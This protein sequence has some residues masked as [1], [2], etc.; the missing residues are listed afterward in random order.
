M[1][2]S[3]IAP[4]T[5]SVPRK[6]DKP[7]PP[8]PAQGARML[9]YRKAAGLTQA[10]LAVAVGETQVNI[11]FWERSEKPPRSDVLPKLAAALGVSVND[12]LGLTSTKAKPPPLQTP[13][14]PASQ[15]QKAFEEVRRLPRRQQQK[16]LDVVFAMLEQHNR[17]AS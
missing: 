8:R 1:R 10:E 12:L 14:G 15:V 2:F 7:S 11:S 3:K 16:I 4:Y 6:P 5:G 17:K 13:A 9:A